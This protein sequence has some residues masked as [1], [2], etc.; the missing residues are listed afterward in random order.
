MCGT[1]PP[2]RWRTGGIEYL[3]GERGHRLEFAAAEL[4]FAA[5]APAVERPGPQNAARVSGADR[6]LRRGGQREWER[7]G[8]LRTGEQAGDEA[9]E[10]PE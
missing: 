1:G 5:A 8:R 3:A 9:C 10:Q 7:P 4:P 6:E 2:Q